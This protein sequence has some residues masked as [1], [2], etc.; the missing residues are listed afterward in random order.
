MGRISQQTAHCQINSDLSL[1]LHDVMRSRDVCCWLWWHQRVDHWA[2]R[3]AAVACLLTELFGR[4]WPTLCTRKGT[5]A[6]FASGWTEGG[7][8]RRLSVTQWMDEAELAPVFTV[9]RVWCLLQ[10]TALEKDEPFVKDATRKVAPRWS[11][12]WLFPASLTHTHTLP[13]PQR[14][15]WFPPCSLSIFYRRVIYNRSVNGEACI[16]FLAP[17]LFFTYW[18][19]YRSQLLCFFHF[20]VLQPESAAVFPWRTL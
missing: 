14:C 20:F 8:A 5:S 17:F 13:L 19:S 4:V 11:G 9:Q 16:Y 6:A 15:L 1:Q 2:S 18:L 12:A 7:L 3:C 10:L